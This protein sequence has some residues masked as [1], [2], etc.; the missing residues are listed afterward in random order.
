MEGR[1]PAPFHILSLSASATTGSVIG[2]A[3]VIS[4]TGSASSSA[5][6]S[7]RVSLLPPLP[8]T[9]LS[10]PIVP[11]QAARTGEGSSLPAR[12]EAENVQELFQELRA[13][14]V[15]SEADL[16]RW[17]ACRAIVHGWRDRVNTMDEVGRA[18]TQLRALPH[19]RR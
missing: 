11:C 8:Y 5:A 14:V 4:T 13:E 16:L 9:P 10:R 6:I 12:I 18:S 2:T 3:L 7:Q 19:R 17:V 15:Q 1:Y